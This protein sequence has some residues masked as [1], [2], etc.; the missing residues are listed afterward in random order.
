MRI[1]HMCACANNYSKCVNGKRLR[2]I[3]L[4]YASSYILESSRKKNKIKENIYNVAAN[5]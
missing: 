5:C 3:I 4:L 2:V 1:M